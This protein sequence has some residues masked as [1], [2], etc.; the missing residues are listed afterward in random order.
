MCQWKSRAHSGV[1]SLS[2]AQMPGGVPVAT[3]AISE[4]RS[5]KCSPLCPP[6]LSVE[7][8]AA[9]T[10]A[11]FAEKNKEKLQRVYQ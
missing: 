6:S 5:D 3:M 11:N 8:Q 10:I 4:A 9:D 2:I 7:D 1:D